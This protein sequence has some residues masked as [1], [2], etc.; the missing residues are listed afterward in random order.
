LKRL[1]QVLGL[2]LKVV[3]FDNFSQAV[4]A[5]AAG[6]VDVLSSVARTPE[7][8]KVLKFT[9]SYLTLPV[10]YIGRR[11]LTDF[12]ET[13]D[14]GGLRIAVERGYPVH[15]WLLQEHP[16]AHMLVVGSTLEALR[17]VAEGRADFYR[18]R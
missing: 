9:R 4:S 13:A 8:E 5:A 7:R 17:A 18:G 6:Q 3:R 11:G 2:R 12:T 1:A 10:V 16:H 14:F 15:E